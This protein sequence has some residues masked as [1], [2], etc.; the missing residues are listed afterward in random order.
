MW[1]DVLNPLW[2]TTKPDSKIAGALCEMEI[3]TEYRQTL[4]NGKFDEVFP[5]RSNHGFHKAVN[6]SPA[7]HRYSHYYG[8]FPI[9]LLPVECSKQVF[10]GHFTT[11]PVCGCLRPNLVKHIDDRQ[12]LRTLMR[13]RIKH[14]VFGLQSSS[15]W[16][17]SVVLVFSPVSH[18][19]WNPGCI[20]A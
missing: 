1:Q 5:A 18:L 15:R 20:T 8:L 11:F 17:C 14:I 3:N 19:F 4:V 12:K 10:W 6:L 2:D 13:W 9:N 7:F 16:S